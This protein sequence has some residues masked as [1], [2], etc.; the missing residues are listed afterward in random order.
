M[1]MPTPKFT[2]IL[3]SALMATAGLSLTACEKGGGSKKKS[4]RLRW[5][6]KPTTGTTED[7][8]KIIKIPGI[9]IDFY[10]PD[11]LYVYKDCVE[12]AHS[13]EG[14]DA[15][16]VPVIR[17]SSSAG[18][19]EDES[20]YDDWEEGDDED[21]YGDDRVLT[22]YV[23]DKSDMIINERATASYKLQYEQAGFE[24]E[25]LN[26]FDEYLAKPGRRGIEVVAHTVDSD[27]GYPDREIRR[28]MFPKGDV[29]FI[30]H[31]DYPFG[32]D[33]SGINSDWERIL[34]NFQF[35]EDGALFE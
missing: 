18:G 28:F 7:D 29:V 19:D 27:S 9:A 12:A 6:N 31:V 32:Q 3:L 4:E 23:T 21:D 13:P 2:S 1:T 8:G 33:R 10:T 5:V 22:I 30:A 26:Y 20:D 24:V 25:S 14:P 15:K 35:A 16:W 17:C 11:V 34:W